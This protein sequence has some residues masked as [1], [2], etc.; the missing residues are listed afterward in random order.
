MS[1]YPSEKRDSLTDDVS[2]PTK[3]TAID[4]SSIHNTSPSPTRNL[5]NIDTTNPQTYEL[6]SIETDWVFKGAYSL[7][8]R[9]DDP[10]TEIWVVKI[11]S[12]A[13]EI[14]RSDGTLVGTAGLHSWSSKVDVCMHNAP[15]VPDFTMTSKGFCCMMSKKLFSL[16]GMEYHWRSASK[17]G[18]K[19]RLEDSAGDAIAWV[20]ATSWKGRYNFEL[21]KAGLDRETVEAVMITGLAVLENEKRNTW[22]ASSAASSSAASSVAISA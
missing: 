20:G 1:Y 10:S 14:F 4:I 15:S 12:K 6:K 9:R 16:N 18:M 17:M 13:L 8:L 3:E 21:I 7:R 2:Y 5:L 19:F 22:A 11:T